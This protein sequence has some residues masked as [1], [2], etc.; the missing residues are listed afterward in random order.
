MLKS[1]Y[2]LKQFLRNW[3]THLHEFIISMALDFNG[4]LDHCMYIG[5]IDSHI[6]IV[7]VFVND[8]L[9][10]STCEDVTANVRLLLYA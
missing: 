9:L 1:P 2:G 6:V 8:T 4:Q 3:N 5:V 7:V 10:A